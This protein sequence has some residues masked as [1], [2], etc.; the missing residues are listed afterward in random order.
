MK[1]FLFKILIASQLFIFVLNSCSL[2]D[3]EEVKNTMENNAIV[4][5]SNAVF[6]YEELSIG[7]ANFRTSDY[8]LS[9]GKKKHGLT[10]AMAIRYK[11]DTALQNAS[12][13]VYPGYEAD[14]N[15]YHIEVLE[16]NA[17][18]VKLKLTHP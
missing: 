10:A 13:V 17:N 11:A 2:S 1:K 5:N 8:T 15:G 18:N 16:V 12:F 4:I 7:V 9:N 3:S 6:R 14:I